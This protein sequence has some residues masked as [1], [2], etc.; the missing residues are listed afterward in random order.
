MG[1]SSPQYAIDRRLLLQAIVAG[2][3]FCAMRPAFS[4]ETVVGTVSEI[5]GDVIAER[6]D[7][8]R[9]LTENHRS[10]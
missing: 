3:A 8:R 7:Q 4:A 1:Q 5:V 9:K 6:N 10:F 2:T